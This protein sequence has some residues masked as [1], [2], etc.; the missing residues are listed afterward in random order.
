MLM[1]GAA[2][3]VIMCLATSGAAAQNKA[4]TEAPKADNMPVVGGYADESVKGA[5]AAK[6]HDPEMNGI[7]F[8]TYEGFEKTWKLVTVTYRTDVKEMR[9]SYAND[10]AYETL[11]NNS[12]D[13]PDG[14]TFI[15]VAVQ[16]LGDPAFI[17][18]EVP[19]GSHRYQVMLKDR[20]K[21]KATDGWGY[22]SFAATTWG[23]DV[24]G[25]DGKIAKD[26]IYDMQDKCHA[27]HTLV[28]DRG[29]VF[30]KLANINPAPGQDVTSFTKRPAPKATAGIEFKTIARSDLPEPL[31]QF[32]PADAYTLRRV[33][34]L[35]GKYG[36]TGNAYEMRMAF[37]VEALRSKMPVIHYKEDGGSIL[38]VAPTTKEAEPVSPT[39]KD[40]DQL[41]V[42]YWNAGGGVENWPSKDLFC[43][44]EESVPKLLGDKK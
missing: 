22:A 19:Q 6:G 41:L 20:H 33:T 25:W 2:L 21:Y 9:F 18:S 3:A 1:R 32:V 35:L 14:A 17:N 29:F 31:R 42:S 23:Y 5:K 4:I 30:S 15:K 27:C 7:R 44:G 28:K 40:G 39:C 34:G 10:K 24:Y 43:Y 13:Y 26:N 8:S 36:Y 11:I 12:T 16:T 38:V 37:I